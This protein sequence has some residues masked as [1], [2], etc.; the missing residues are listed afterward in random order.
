[1]KDQEKFSICLRQEM[2]KKDILLIKDKRN[3]MHIAASCEINLQ[4]SKCY[5]ELYTKGTE[6]TEKMT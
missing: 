5:C 6:F 1:M 3:I 2:N 4:F